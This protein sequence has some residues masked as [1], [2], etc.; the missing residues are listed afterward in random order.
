MFPYGL[1]GELLGQQERGGRMAKVVEA[2]AR[3]P[4]S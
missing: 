3:Q 1:E 2:A 4:G